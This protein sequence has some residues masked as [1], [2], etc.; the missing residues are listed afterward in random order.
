MMGF[1]VGEAHLDALAL[2]ARLGERLGLHLASRYVARIFVNIA[3]A[4]RR[5]GRRLVLPIMP[6]RNVT[7]HP[8]CTT[9]SRGRMRGA[10]YNCNC[11]FGAD[12]ADAARISAGR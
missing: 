9:A 8:G 3:A 1:K 6:D 10:I 12:L 11:E 7:H 2:I 4:A 5:N